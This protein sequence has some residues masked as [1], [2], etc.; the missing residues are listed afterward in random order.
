MTCHFDL[1]IL[2][3]SGRLNFLKTV[4]EKITLIKLL[5]ICKSKTAIDITKLYILSIMLNI[6]PKIEKGPAIAIPKEFLKILSKIFL[7]ALIFFF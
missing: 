1:K 3:C 4:G 6:T 5:I 2:L 7:K